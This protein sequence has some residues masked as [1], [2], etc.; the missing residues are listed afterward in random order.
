MEAAPTVQAG[1]YHPSMLPV[2][3]YRSK[4]ETSGS[5][6]TVVATGPGCRLTL[7]AH[8]PDHIEVLHTIQLVSRRLR[9]SGRIV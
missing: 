4:D 8:V 6:A 3:G 2:R 7:A 9:K 5:G 1:L